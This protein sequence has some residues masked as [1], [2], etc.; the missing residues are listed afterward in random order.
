VFLLIS[1]VRFPTLADFLHPFVRNRDS[2]WE[3]HMGCGCCTQLLRVHLVAL[4]HSFVGCLHRQL[5]CAAELWQRAALDPDFWRSCEA[6]KAWVWDAGR[7]LHFL[8]L[9]GAENLMVHIHA[10][11]RTAKVQSSCLALNGSYTTFFSVDCQVSCCTLMWLVYV[12]FLPL[13][14]PF[15]WEKKACRRLCFNSVSSLKTVVLLFGG[16]SCIPWT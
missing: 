9:Q 7:L 8:L 14:S 5:H 13:L 11:L 16:Y 4:H 6:K 1:S 2:L 10:C 3:W 12:V 15:L